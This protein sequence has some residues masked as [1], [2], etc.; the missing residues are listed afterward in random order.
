MGQ[1]IGIDL[2]TTHSAAAVVQGSVPVLVPNAMGEVLTPSVVGVTTRGEV[3]VGRAAQE[4]AATAPDRCRSLFKREMGQRTEH[5]IGDLRL[6]PQMLSSLVL[7]ALRADAEAFLGDRVSGAVITVPAYF[8]DAQRQATKDAAELAGLTVERILNEPTAAALAYGLHADADRRRLLVFDLGGGTFDVSVV[9]CEDGI[10]EVLASAGEALLGGEDFTRNLMARVLASRQQSL[11]ELEARRP[12]LAAKLRYRFELA[13]RQLSVTPEAHVPMPDLDAAEWSPEGAVTV[14]EAGLRE[15]NAALLAR[16]A[17]TTWAALRD[18]HLSPDDIDHVLLVGGASRM[19]AVGEFVAALFGREPA[20]EIDADTVVARGAAVQAALV[21]GNRAV[22]DLVA[23]DVMPHTLG[24]EVCKDFAGEIKGGY[25]LPIID[26]NTT[27]PVSRVVELA[28]THDGQTEMSVEIYQGEARCVQENLH[29]GTLVVSDLQPRPRGHEGVRLRYTYDLNGILE[30]DAELLSTGRQHRLVLQ[31]RPGKLTDVE[32][33]RAL[34]AMQALKVDPRDADQN[35]YLLAKGRRLFS[36]VAGVHRH[37]LD[38]LL[39]QFER[40][41]VA[42][43]HDAAEALRAEL[44]LFLS[45]LEG[46]GTSA[47]RD[48]AA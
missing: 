44:Q 29:L 14:T 8:N 41:L 12:V 24:T 7:R 3:V 36:E 4:I 27:I 39:T 23:T 1:V 22:R 28:T 21:A 20:G 33:R 2:G 42:R 6:T 48:G 35:R 37:R 45:L 25:F 46:D 11:P 26:R 18:A 30:V 16:L 15:A 40:A 31:E 10:L 17:P 9:D 13:K 47:S 34:H 32:L 19:T 38:E 43:E 5:R